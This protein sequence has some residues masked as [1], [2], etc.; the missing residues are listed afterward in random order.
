MFNAS[1]ISSLNFFK[2]VRSL[3]KKLGN[4]PIV[5]Q[6]IYGNSLFL[7][8]FSLFTFKKFFQIVT[9]CYILSFQ[10]NCSSQ[11]FT[12]A[13]WIVYSLAIQDIMQLQKPE[14]VELMIHNI[15]QILCV[16]KLVLSS[17]LQICRSVNFWTMLVC[18]K[19]EVRAC[20]HFVSRDKQF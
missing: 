7:F 20:L 10:Y 4:F 13:V 12:F 5:I 3:L 1:L 14:F 18:L 8:L 17:Q 9:I 6:G 11:G 15:C 19:L 16:L 2:F